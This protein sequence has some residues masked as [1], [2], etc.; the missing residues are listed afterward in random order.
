[1]IGGFLQIQALELLM[2]FSEGI[3]GD[4]AW[5]RC[6]RPIFPSPLKPR[7]LVRSHSENWV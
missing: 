4:R 7:F 1:M 6:D 2:G 5:R 3:W